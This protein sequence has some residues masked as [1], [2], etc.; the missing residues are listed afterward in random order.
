MLLLCECCGVDL[1]CC[2]RWVC[3]SALF[4]FRRCVHL[5]SNPDSIARAFVPDTP[6]P[7][8]PPLSLSRS[9]RC[10]NPPFLGDA[11]ITAHFLIV[12]MVNILGGQHLAMHVHWFEVRFA[13]PRCQG[14]GRVWCRGVAWGSWW[15]HESRFATLTEYDAPP[16]HHPSPF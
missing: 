12:V 9:A 8:S 4:R 14:G 3:C 5:D 13:L 1:G 7:I 16:V 6:R 15:C 2:C 11:N 10:S